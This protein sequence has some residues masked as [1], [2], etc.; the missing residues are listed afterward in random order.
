MDA[1]PVPLLEP[2]SDEVFAAKLS[3]FESDHLT[4]AGFSWGGRIGAIVLVVE[5]RFK[6]GVLNQAGINASDHADINMVSFLLRVKTPALQFN[7]R[8]DVD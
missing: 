4:Y 1:E 7:G 5:D 2:F 3:D 6:L 8:Y